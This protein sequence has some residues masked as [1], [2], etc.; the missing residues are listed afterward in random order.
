M[1]MHCNERDVKGRDIELVVSKTCSKW[2]RA[3]DVVNDGDGGEGSESTGGRRC[4]R[5]AP[6]DTD[7]MDGRQDR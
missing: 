1:E 7:R 2:C 6:Q 3:E 4:V 5:F